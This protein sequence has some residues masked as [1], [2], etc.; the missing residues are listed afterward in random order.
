M[1]SWGALPRI[2]RGLDLSRTGR[3]H[4]PRSS[5]ADGNVDPYE[6]PRGSRCMTD[7][8]VQPSVLLQNVYL[9]RNWQIDWLMTFHIRR[10]T[11]INLENGK[12]NPSLKLAMDITYY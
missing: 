4:N 8:I 3:L 1:N 10:E 12:Y 5:L 6:D 11:I 2:P 7:W 9:L